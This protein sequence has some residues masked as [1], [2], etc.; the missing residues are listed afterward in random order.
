MKG[1]LIAPSYAVQTV[2]TKRV[3]IA[4]RRSAFAGFLILEMDLSN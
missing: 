4:D 2:M 3:L 1:R